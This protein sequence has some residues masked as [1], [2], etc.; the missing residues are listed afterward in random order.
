MSLLDFKYK[1]FDLSEI[2][3]ILTA[4]ISMCGDFWYVVKKYYYGKSGH[5]VLPDMFKKYSLNMCPSW[6]KTVS[7]ECREVRRKIKG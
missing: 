5:G 1:T 6:P 7:F 4:Y 3:D 2:Y